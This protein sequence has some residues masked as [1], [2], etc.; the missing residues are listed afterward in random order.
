MSDT[1]APLYLGG[2]VIGIRIF[3]PAKLTLSGFLFHW[4]STGIDTAESEQLGDGNV[5]G[6]ELATDQASQESAAKVARMEKAGKGRTRSLLPTLRP[7]P[8]AFGQSSQP[9]GDR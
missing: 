2:G 7:A 3:V 5:A 6:S 4:T 8:V 9:S 1:V